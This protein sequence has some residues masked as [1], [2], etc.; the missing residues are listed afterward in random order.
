MPADIPVVILCGGRGTRMGFVDLPKPM[1][2]I[3]DRPI[4]W[5]IMSIYAYYGFTR[6]VL[7]L[8]YKK[9]KIKDY[10]KNIRHWQI[11]FVDT[12]LDTNTG[13][14]IKRIEPVIKSDIFLASYGD[15]LSDVNIK[16][17]LNFHQRHKRIATLTSVRPYSQFGIIGI[18]AR[19]S[20]VTYFQEKPQLDH[21]INA[22]F[23]VFSRKIFQYLKDNDILE[24]DTLPRL[25]KE[26]KLSAYKH[27][28]FWECMDTYKDN[29]RLNQLWLQGKAPWAVW[30][31]RK[32]NER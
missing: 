26:K 8:G 10:F 12:G 21:W 20:R 15:A 23:F 28:G 17:L 16:T 31:E 13:G 9:E 4:L 32:K 5:H 7:A 24:Q 6:F 30:L 3:G 19:T 18:D 27:S 14:R 11:D 22:G 2:H 1:F 29:L 25:V